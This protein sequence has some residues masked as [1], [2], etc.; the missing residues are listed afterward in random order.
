VEF[1]ASNAVDWDQEFSEDEN[2]AFDFKQPPPDASVT[3]LEAK[4][5]TDQAG[6]SLSD[7]LR[8]LVGLT[9]FGCN[10][11]VASKGDQMPA[12]GF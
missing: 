6:A 5:E 3:K 8:G 1:D 12:V 9:G 7:R 10:H 4:P 2:S 11:R